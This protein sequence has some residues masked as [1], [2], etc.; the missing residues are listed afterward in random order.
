MSWWTDFKC[1]IVYISYFCMFKYKLSWVCLCFI[2]KDF[3]L[4]L[5]SQF[6]LHVLNVKLKN[7]AFAM[8]MMESGYV[9]VWRFI[10]MTDTYGKMQLFTIHS[11]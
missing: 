7:A 9:N 8:A 6:F 4:F 2:Y 5:I 10:I 3:E 11:L 1:V